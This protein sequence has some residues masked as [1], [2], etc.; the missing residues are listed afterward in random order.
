M[1]DHE[2]HVTGSV[3]ITLVADGQDHLEALRGAEIALHRAKEAGGGRFTLFDDE[4]ERRSLARLDME[5]DLHDMLTHRRWWLEYQPI[6]D[7]VSRQV[8]AVEALLRWTHPTRGPVPP[9]DLISLAEH[10]GTIVALGHDIFERACREAR[11]WH[12]HGFDLPVSINVSVRQLREPSFLED[13]RTTLEATGVAPEK[14]VLELTETVLATNDHGEIDTLH[15]LRALGCRVAI[16]DFG[17]GYS[18]LSELR[19]L[20]I[21]V[22][23]LDHSFIT[24]LTSSP[25]PPPWWRR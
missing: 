20:P 18:S 22:V 25:R 8:V 19:D 23:K 12:D 7:T 15:A 4:L 24:G 3:G 13:V 16:D 2:L 6:V 11:S 5:A 14:V 9:F 1:G 17:T 21:D 10:S